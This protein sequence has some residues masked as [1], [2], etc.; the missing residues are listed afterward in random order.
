M[1]AIWLA[2]AIT[3]AVVLSAYLALHIGAVLFAYIVYCMG[4][5]IL[6]KEVSFRKFY[7]EIFPYPGGK[8]KYVKEDKEK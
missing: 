4:E 8:E 6:G 7:K 2:V 5:S 3:V 1:N